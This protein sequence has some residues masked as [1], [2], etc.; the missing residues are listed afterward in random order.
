MLLGAHFRS[1]ACEATRGIVLS[2]CLLPVSPAQLLSRSALGRPARSTAPRVRQRA[3]QH[4]G[5]RGA[6]QAAAGPGAGQA[7]AGPGACIEQDT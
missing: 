5:T 2:W 7:A 3:K 6:G 4:Q 1:A